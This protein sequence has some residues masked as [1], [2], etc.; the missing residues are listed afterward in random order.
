MFYTSDIVSV[1]SFL[2]PKNTTQRK[3]MFD[4]LNVQAPILIVKKSELTAFLLQHL[5]AI[6][7]IGLRT[8]HFCFVFRYAGACIISW[9]FARHQHQQRFKTFLGTDVVLTDNEQTRVIKAGGGVSSLLC[10][11]TGSN[12]PQAH[13]AQRVWYQSQNHGQLSWSGKLN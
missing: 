8:A 12:L 9:N 4:E 2:A 11:C 1:N 10:V 6:D 5:Q 3:I 7:Y 13:K